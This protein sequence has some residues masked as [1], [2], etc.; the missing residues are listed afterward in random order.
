[1]ERRQVLA[2]GVADLEPARDYLSDFSEE[3]FID[4]PRAVSIVVPFPREVVELLAK[5]PSRTYL[6]FYREVNLRLNQIALEID[7]ILFSEGHRSFPVPASRREGKERIS[8]LFPHR[9][10]AHLAGLGWIGKSGLLIRSDAGPR[11]RLVTVLTDAPLEASSPQEDQCGSCT[12]CIDGCPPGAIAEREDHD[13]WRGNRLDRVLCDQHLA[14]VRDR[15]GV[16]VCGLCLVVC[17][18]GRDLAGTKIHP[19]SAPNETD[20]TEQEGPELRSP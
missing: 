10:A 11:L 6:Y 16:R 19:Q 7:S 4:L 12:E 17:P 14:K 3:H 2:W 8:S 15:H 5:G 1:M 18:W 20:D 13:D 9:L